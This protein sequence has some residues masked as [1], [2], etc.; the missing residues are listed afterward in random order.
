VTDGLEIEVSDGI[1]T[2]TLARPERRNAMGEVLVKALRSFFFEPPPEVRAAVIRG[3]GDHFCAGLD[4]EEMSKRNPYEA[5]QHSRLWHD[6]FHRLEQGTVPVVAALHGAVIGGGLELATSC[7]VRVAADSAFYSLPEGRHGIFVGGGGSV[8]IARVIGSDRMREL[9]LT[10][11]RLDAD[12]GHALGISHYRAT[13]D[14]LLARA[15]EIALHIAGNAPIANQLILAALPRIDDMSRADGL[16]TESL[17]AGM[18]GT[19][20]DAAEGLRAFLEKRPAQFK[21]R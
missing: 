10:G 8:R 14:E 21:G 4:L 7:H 20:E 15:R 1:A 12:E 3:A 6:A 17:T 5:M 11:R 19:T 16:F 13:D 18:A 2:L 9:M